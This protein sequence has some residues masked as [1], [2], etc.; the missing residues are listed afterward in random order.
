MVIL[1][2]KRGVFFVADAVMYVALRTLIKDQSNLVQRI[3]QSA[4]FSCC[5]K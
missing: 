5:R 2:S 4:L 3:T 1:V